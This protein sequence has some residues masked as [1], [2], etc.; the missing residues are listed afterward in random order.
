MPIDFP[1]LRRQNVMGY[2]QDLG[3][4]SPFMGLP[5]EIIEPNAQPAP[6]NEQDFIAQRMRQLY[7]PET[8]A[9]D[10]LNQMMNEFPQ[11][12]E[13]SNLRKIGASMMGLR[14]VGKKNQS[15]QDAQF[16]TNLQERFMDKPYAHGVEDWKLK[17]EPA[18]K[19]ADIERS[20]NVNERGFANQILSQELGYRK[21]EEVERKNREQQRL[22]GERNSLYAMRQNMPDWDWDLRGPTVV[23]KNR[24][25]GEIKQTQI[26]TGK[27]S[28]T[29]RINLQGEWGV[30]REEAATDRALA[31]EGARQPNRLEV[32]EAGGEEARKTKTTPSSS[33]NNALEVSREKLA[34][35]TKLRDTMPGARNWIRISNNGQV[36]VLPTT[37][38]TS[39]ANQKIRA[40]I[41]KQLYGMPNEQK[42]NSQFRVDLPNQAPP[43][44]NQGQQG[45]PMRRP[46]T[47]S[48]G[49]KGFAIST[50]G[51]KT[52]QLE[53]Q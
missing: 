44:Q 24:K 7:N 2:G 14:N 26:E 33:S 29:D 1:R 13:P 39:V 12:K 18:I 21:Q 47:S 32:I 53:Q 23:M 9:S 34:L 4:I 25:T 38:F 43:A 27:L 17:M 16:T 48:T 5:E 37:R 31:V 6:F 28:D 35:A 46:V 3:P 50:D 49:R 11:R 45:Q 15:A 36:E 52:W 40:D 8:Q 41:I 42:P 22:Q 20:G 10:R 30:K 51:G 19:A